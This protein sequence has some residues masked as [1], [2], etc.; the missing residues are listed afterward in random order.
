MN[1]PPYLGWSE[2]A[3]SIEGDMIARIH[4]NNMDASILVALELD[5][6]ASLE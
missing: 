1:V 3:I 5:M 4:N 6:P 2:T